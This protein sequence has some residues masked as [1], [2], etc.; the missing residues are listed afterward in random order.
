VLT[1]RGAIAALP[2]VAARQIKAWIKASPTLWNA[3]RKAQ[4]ATGRFKA[5]R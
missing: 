2:I 5:F 3:F 1:V 4:A